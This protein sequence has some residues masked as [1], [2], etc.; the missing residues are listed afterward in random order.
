MELHHIPSANTLGS[1]A[2]GPGLGDG[3]YYD[4]LGGK[5]PIASAPEPSTWAMM[6]L[7]FAGLASPGIALRARTSRSP[8]NGFHDTN[9]TRPPTIGGLFRVS[10]REITGVTDRTG[11]GRLRP[12]LSASHDGVTSRSNR[13]Y[14]LRTPCTSASA[15]SHHQP[16]YRINTSSNDRNPWSRLL[17]QT[18]AR[19]QSLFEGSGLASCSMSLT[20]SRSRSASAA[21]ASRSS[22]SEVRQRNVSARQRVGGDAEFGCAGAGGDPAALSSSMAVANGEHRSRVTPPRIVGNGAPRKYSSRQGPDA[23]PRSQPQHP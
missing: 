8:R 9:T 5:S 18:V 10:C 2:S 12:D 4:W 21:S 3:Q 16:D 15:R 17:Y 11:R 22:S 14:G 1:T 13:P 6:A 20:S 7:G 23:A 19:F